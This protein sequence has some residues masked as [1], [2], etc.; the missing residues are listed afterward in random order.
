[1]NQELAQIKY[2][3]NNVVLEW[4]Y[5][6]GD[7]LRTHEIEEGGLKIIIE[8]RTELEWKGKWD[9]NPIDDTSEVESVKFLIESVK[10]YIYDEE[11]EFNN[12]KQYIKL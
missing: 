11:L 10:A 12:L 9:L 1:M 5:L 6:D 2:L 7:S 4:D 3:L 8:Y